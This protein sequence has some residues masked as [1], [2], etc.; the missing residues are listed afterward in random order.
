MP[1]ASTVRILD[2]N[3]HMSNETYSRS[4]RERKKVVIETWYSLHR[5]W[6]V[7]PPVW[8]SSRSVSQG[9]LRRKGTYLNAHAVGPQNSLSKL[10]PSMGTWMNVPFGTNICEVASSVTAPCA[11]FRLI[12]VEIGTVPSFVA[13]RIDECT[14]GIS[15]MASRITFS[16]YGNS[17][18][19]A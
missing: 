10:K 7:V 14:G 3:T 12:G 6:Q 15:R 13:T 4:G 11:A 17:A 16:R 8:A 2:R 19:K 9:V 18:T 5:F 1:R